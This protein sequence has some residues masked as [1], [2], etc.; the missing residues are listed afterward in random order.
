MPFCAAWVATAVALCSVTMC[1][2]FGASNAD[3]NAVRPLNTDAGDDFD[4]APN[5]PSPAPAD[6]FGNGNGHDG[7]FVR[8]QGAKGRINTYFAVSAPLER[9]ALR[10]TLE[11]APGVS[12]LGAGDLVMIWQAAGN[13]PRAACVPSMGL[14]AFAG[15]GRYELARVSSIDGKVVVVGAALSSAYSGRTQ[16]VRVPEYTNVSIE[17]DVEADPWDGRKGG[18]VALL[19]TGAV[20][21]NGAFVADQAGFAG[22]AGTLRLAKDTSNCGGENQIATVVGY[23][24]KGE[25]IFGESGSLGA[26]C[27]G[28]GGGGGACIN[29]GGGG[30]GHGGAGGLGGRTWSKDSVD[31]KMGRAE[32]SGRGGAALDDYGP[33]LRLLMG[34]GGGAGEADDGDPLPSGGAGGGV[35]FVRASQIEE[36]LSIDVSGG[37]GFSNSASAGGGGG[38]GGLIVLRA[39]TVALGDAKANGGNGGDSLSTTESNGPGGGGGGG[40]IWIDSAARS[41]G[42]YAA[43][44]GASGVLKTTGRANDAW[45][46]AAGQPGRV[47]KR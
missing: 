13:S 6:A 5:V 34:G 11:T 12:G 25:G 8:A 7:P 38:A 18:I 27:F 14:A 41:V 30:G 31:K 42:T 33:A 36:S 15:A 2:P 16:L 1:T 23:T 21:G 43:K 9:G 17:G 19:A 35:V 44:G 4:A 24:Q 29:A 32:P 26:P 28:S 46:A 47:T 45:G 37:P 40:V 39:T 10:I 22:G 20:R 3:V